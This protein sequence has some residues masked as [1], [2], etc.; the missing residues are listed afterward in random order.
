MPWCNLS[1]E[2]AALTNTD[3]VTSPTHSWTKLQCTSTDWQLSVCTTARSSL[4]TT[5][6]QP[7]WKYMVCQMQPLYKVKSI[8]GAT[9]ASNC[10][11][12]CLHMPNI[13][14]KARAHKDGE[15]NKTCRHKHGLSHCAFCLQSYFTCAREHI[16][17]HY[18]VFV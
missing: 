14:L 10:S 16:S 15:E 5:F 6:L 9:I 1:P 2:A 17:F 13:A 7:S 18:H 11:S 12:S 8:I 3:S 4:L